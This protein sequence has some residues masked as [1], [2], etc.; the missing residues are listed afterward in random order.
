MCHSEML[1]VEERIQT[2]KL[3]CLDEIDRY[4]WG[5]VE[6]ATRIRPE[7]DVK[8]VIWL[9]IQRVFVTNLLN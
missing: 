8:N 2:D 1:E 3:I 7:V 5:K 6:G 4:R 9:L